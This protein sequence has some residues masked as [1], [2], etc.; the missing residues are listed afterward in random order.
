MT[1]DWSP[2]RHLG[3]TT[4]I[5]A[6]FYPGYGRDSI[7]LR[8]LD[9]STWR[10]VLKDASDDDD[11]R[12]QPVEFYKEDGRVHAGAGVP[13]FGELGGREGGRVGVGWGGS[14]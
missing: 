8:L 14:S 7:T 3:K 5:A 4:I 11:D 13:P 12:V 1:F 2:A 6:L 9:V 10:N